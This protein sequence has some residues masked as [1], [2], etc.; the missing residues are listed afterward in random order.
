MLF[1][2]FYLD[3]ETNLTLVSTLTAFYSPMASPAV[4]KEIICIIFCM[5]LKE[6]DT[7]SSSFIFSPN[8]TQ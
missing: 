5:L 7:R 6:S 4:T 2:S 1:K 8:K 3:V